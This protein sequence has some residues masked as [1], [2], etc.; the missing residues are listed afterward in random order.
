MNGVTIS[1]AAGYERIGP[2]KGP[3]RLPGVRVISRRTDAG[4]QVFDASVDPLHVFPVPDE[5]RSWSVS[6]TRDA[7]VYADDE[8]VVRIDADGGERWRFRL[9]PCSP[10]GESTPADAQFSADDALVWVYVP[11]FMC[12][13]GETD[14]WIVLDAATGESRSRRPVPSGGQGGR[15]FPLDDGRMMLDVGEGQN[16]SRIFLASPDGAVHD[17]GWEDRVLID[18][19][20]DQRQFMTV[21]HQGQEDV[22][23]HSLPGGEVLFRLD[24]AAFGADPEV[25]VV[26]WAGGYLD[27]GTVVV[28]I[29]GDE[30]WRH[31]RV[32]THTGAV[33]GDLGIVTI[34]ENDLQPLGDGTYVITDTDGTLRRM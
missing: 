3:F 32:D 31:H 19:S 20:P 9:G 27:A 15:Q 10:P 24:V 22:A 12:G 13:R 4:V 23:L 6:S 28:V 2:G 17:F 26:E 1:T 18:V 7:L 11:T 33:L 16:G 21:D 8:D 34:D 5:V 29:L 25:E 30:D 14:E